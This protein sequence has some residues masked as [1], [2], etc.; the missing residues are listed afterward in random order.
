M[1]NI[2]NISL[3]VEYQP[4]TKITKMHNPIFESVKFVDSKRKPENFEL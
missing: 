2:I 3:I 4:H 1:R